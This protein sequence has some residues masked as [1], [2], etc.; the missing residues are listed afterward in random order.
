MSCVSREEVDK[1]YADLATSLSKFTKILDDVVEI[2]D[3]IKRKRYF[4]SLNELNE[5]VSL[6]LAVLRKID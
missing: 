5:A 3:P 2:V 6:A 1:A 4:N